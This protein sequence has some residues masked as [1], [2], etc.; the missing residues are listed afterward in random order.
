MERSENR[1]GL[2]RSKQQLSEQGQ[3]LVGEA[4]VDATAAFPIATSICHENNPPQPDASLRHRKVANLSSL[5]SLHC[6]PHAAFNSA[7][8]CE[9][10]S[11][12][13]R[14]EPAQG[15]TCDGRN[16]VYGCTIRAEHLVPFLVQDDSEANMTQSANARGG[17]PKTCK[18]KQR[19]RA[20][21]FPD[22][23]WYKR[24]STVLARQLDGYQS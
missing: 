13:V 18:H 22:E 14:P 5:P 23:A 12:R 6:K 24:E 2:D 1:C 16:P 8:F 17:G 19:F 10:F 11:E 3:P 20:A 15:P 21:A 7:G 9:S 4:C